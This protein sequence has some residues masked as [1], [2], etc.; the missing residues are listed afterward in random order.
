MNLWFVH[1][2]SPSNHKGEI[3]ILVTASKVHEFYIS[4]IHLLSL[5]W[6][7]E[8]IFTYMH[9]NLYTYIASM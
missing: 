2:I 8:I 1:A 7:V 5:K 6:N 9:V 3:K 4:F